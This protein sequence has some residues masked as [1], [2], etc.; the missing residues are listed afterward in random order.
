MSFKVRSPLR[1]GR[2]KTDVHRTSCALVALL[3]A[4]SSDSAFFS[5]KLFFNLGMLQLIM[6]DYD[7]LFKN[8]CDDGS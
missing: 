1:S 8:F 5:Q 2:R 7:K 4:E 3:D 6:I